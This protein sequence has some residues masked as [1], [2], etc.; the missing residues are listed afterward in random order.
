[1]AY[2]A[3]DFCRAAGSIILNGLNIICSKH[4]KP[5]KSLSLH[6]RMNVTWCFV[7][8]TYGDLIGC[9]SCPASYHLKCINNPPSNL[10]ATVNTSNV[11]KD[12]EEIPNSP[13]PHSADSGTSNHHSPTASVGSSS[14]ASSTCSNVNNK[15]DW[16]CEDCITG[17]R[18]VTGEIVWA[19]ASQ[20]RWWPG[21]VCDSNTLAETKNKQ[22]MHQVGEFTVKFFGTHDYYCTNVSRCFSF[23]ENDDCQKSV[24]GLKGKLLNLA[25]KKAE[26]QAVAAF[27]EIKR[28]KLERMKKISE[29]LGQLKS[30]KKNFQ[31]YQ[32]IKTN[33]PVGNVIV[34]R[35]NMIEWPKCSCDPKSANPCGTEDCLNRILKYECNYLKNL[36]F[37]I[38]TYF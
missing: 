3:N 25:Y 23:H 10:I 32:F 37:E 21:Q 17:K 31:N 29:Q 38:L 14:M 27:K 5:I 22:K 26:Q 9:S 11:K 7:C 4:F 36:T 1:M 2:H 28:L 18:P 12:E 15:T 16:Q 24:N 30:S 20:Y 19:K 6:S 33:K 8:A 34:H 13:L 35:K